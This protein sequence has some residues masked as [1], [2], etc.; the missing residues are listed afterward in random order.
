MTP[1]QSLAAPSITHKARAKRKRRSLRTMGLSVFLVAA[2]IGAVGVI[3]AVLRTAP[4]SPVI[5]NSAPAAPPTNATGTIVL[6]PGVGCQ[7]KVFDNRTGQIFDTTTPCPTET[8]R[9]A[10]G[11]P[12]PLGTAK[13]INS[14]SKSFKE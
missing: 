13:T 2:S 5:D 1:S 9:D 6:H 11:V 14:I 12:V 4:P 7:S 3:S 10:K 8:P